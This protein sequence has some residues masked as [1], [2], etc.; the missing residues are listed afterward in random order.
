MRRNDPLSPSTS[1]KFARML[2]WLTSQFCRPFPLRTPQ[3]V[4][5]STV[6]SL[7]RST[8]TFTA[9]VSRIVGHQIFDREGTGVGRLSHVCRSDS[10]VR[11]YQ[12]PPLYLQSGAQANLHDFRLGTQKY[13]EV[14]TANRSLFLLG[15]PHLIWLFRAKPKIKKKHPVS[16]IVSY[17][18][19]LC[20]TVRQLPGRAADPQPG[21]D[22]GRHEPR[23]GP[24][25]RVREH[26]GLP[27]QG[28]WHAGERNPLPDKAPKSL[29]RAT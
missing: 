24:G 23:Q 29:R 21:G 10:T 17:G 19:R 11:S 27:A 25:A 15:A 20:V 5:L 3:T 16:N 14:S 18:N 8:L 28:F 26:A 1:F 9:T 6:A 13:T 2:V 4:F 22:R 12:R 7:R